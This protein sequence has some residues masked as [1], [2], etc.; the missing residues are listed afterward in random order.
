MF[1]ILQTIFLYL[2]QG[3]EGDY[4][5]KRLHEKLTYIYAEFHSKTHLF[6]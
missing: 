3:E 4:N 5:F 2:F 6:R 1:E